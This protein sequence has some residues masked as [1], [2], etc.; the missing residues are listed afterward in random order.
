MK[1]KDDIYLVVRKEPSITVCGAYCDLILADMAVSAFNQQ[2][3]D[4]GWI[5]E[6]IF[7]V[8]STTYHDER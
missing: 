2:W 7:E 6:D 3:K 8:W 5:T 1:D 4:K